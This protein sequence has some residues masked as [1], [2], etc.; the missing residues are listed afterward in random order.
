MALGEEGDPDPYLPVWGP[1]ELVA[2]TMA[3][4]EEGDPDPDLWGA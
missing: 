4:G 1:D 2:T 3:L